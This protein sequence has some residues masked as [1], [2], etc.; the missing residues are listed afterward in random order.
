MKSHHMSTADELESYFVNTV[1]S[2]P[3]VAASNRTLIYWEE[4]FNNNVTLPKDTI[5]QGWKSGAIG[6]VIKRGH[7]T[8]NS[9]GWYLNH[10]CN[11]YGDGVWTSFYANDPLLYAGAGATA[12]ELSLIIGGETTMWGTFYQHIA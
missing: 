5:I 9:F 4:I 7:R 1:A 10:G 6:G 2:L 12:E 11:D 8:T 3:F